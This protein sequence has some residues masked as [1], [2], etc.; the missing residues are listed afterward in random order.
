[1]NAKGWA[2]LVIIVILVGAIVLYWTKGDHD[3]QPTTQTAGTTH[4]VFSC[5]GGRSIDATFTQ[6][7]AIPSSDPSMPPTPGGSVKLVLSDGREIDLKQTLS[8]DG[9]RYASS[10]E[11]IVFWNVGNGATY[12]EGN[13]DGATETTNCTTQ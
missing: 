9:A 1:M 4:A 8:A 3:M 10:D 2:I 11:S 13:E 6:G 5:D 7:E 12:T